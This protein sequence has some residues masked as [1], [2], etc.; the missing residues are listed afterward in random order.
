MIIDAW[1]HVLKV[2]FILAKRNQY[3]IVYILFLYEK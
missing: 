1:L 2:A 3:L